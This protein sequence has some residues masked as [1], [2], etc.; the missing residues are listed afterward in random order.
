V[1]TDL[2]GDLGVG[3]EHDELAGE[4]AMA[5]N[6]PCPECGGP[7]TYAG[8]DERGTIYTCEAA[9]GACVVFDHWDDD[10]RTYRATYRGEYRALD[11]DD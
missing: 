9:D 7:S 4:T 6:A 10:V 2:A 5:L 3:W 1:A 11:D 8:R